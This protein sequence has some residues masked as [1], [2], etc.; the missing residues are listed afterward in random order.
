MLGAKATMMYRYNYGI[1][2]DSKVWGPRNPLPGTTLQGARAVV[3]STSFIGM[4]AN[5]EPDAA[6]VEK[7]MIFLALSPGSSMRSMR[8]GMQSDQL[9]AAMQPPELPLTE[10]LPMKPSP[11]TAEVLGA[12]GRDHRDGHLRETHPER[13]GSAGTR[14][15]EPARP[16]PSYRGTKKSSQRA[17]ASQRTI[18]PHRVLAHAS[19]EVDALSTYSTDARAQTRLKAVMSVSELPPDQ[20]AE[21]AGMVAEALGDADGN[22]RLA[23]MRALAVIDPTLIATHVPAVMKRIGDGD[24][25]VRMAAMRLLAKLEPPTLARHAAAIVERIADPDCDVRLAV[26]LT[27]AKLKP[28]KLEQLVSTVVGFLRSADSGVRYTALEV[29]SE[30]KYSALEEQ[31]AAIVGMLSDSDNDVRLAAIQLLAR[32]KRDAIV[33]HAAVVVKRLEDPDADVRLTAMRV[34]AK[35][36]PAALVQHAA[37]V[38]QKLVCKTL[39]MGHDDTEERSCTS[40]MGFCY[41]EGAAAEWRMKYAS[42]S[43]QGS[44]EDAARPGGGSRCTDAS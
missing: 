22:V 40:S 1:Y 23:A 13:Q 3:G 9:S 4:S 21:H 6:N 38:V 31:T 36:E 26:V 28:W 24:S 15:A 11:G 25:D 18:L 41:H 39:D 8:T 33:D 27:L 2:R 12:I 7:S 37:E 29:M 30:L 32:L 14:T 19:E 20:V 35:L 44:S 10:Q 34:L 43:F 42:S 5:A 17:G 16:A